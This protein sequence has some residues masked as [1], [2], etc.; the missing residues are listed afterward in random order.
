VPGKNVG[1]WQ[2]SSASCRFADIFISRT[3]H[4]SA[5]DPVDMVF[6]DGRNL[7]RKI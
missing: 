5:S 3:S 1:A 6:F 2:R 4:F 7:F